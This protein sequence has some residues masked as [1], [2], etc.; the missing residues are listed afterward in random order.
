M[1]NGSDSVVIAGSR[2]CKNKNKMRFSTDV[3]LTNTR[4]AEACKVVKLLL[5]TIVDG[6]Q[7]LLV[8]L[9]H[10]MAMRMYVGVALDLSERR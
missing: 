5:A 7:A 2:R 3:R 10:F 6:A 4:V 9:S 1:E 8:E